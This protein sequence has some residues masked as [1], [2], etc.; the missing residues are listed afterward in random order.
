MAMKFEIYWY[1][2]DRAIISAFLYNCRDNDLTEGGKISKGQIVKGCVGYAMAE[3]DL[4]GYSA[5]IVPFR[6]NRTCMWHEHELPCMTHL[7]VP[8]GKVPAAK[9]RPYNYVVAA[10]TDPSFEA[11]AQADG[12]PVVRDSKGQLFV[13]LEVSRFEKQAKY[14]QARLLA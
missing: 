11:E 1:R 10:L 6:P 12:L 2:V 7:D 5:T 14:R 8:P 9:L 3:K 4:E 13:N